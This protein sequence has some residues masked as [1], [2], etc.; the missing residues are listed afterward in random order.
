MSLGW[1]HS[2]RILWAATGSQPQLLVPSL[3]PPLGEAVPKLAGRVLETETA[4]PCK[5]N[6]PPPLQN[7]VGDCFS[8][9]EGAGVEKAISNDF[10]GMFKLEKDVVPKVCKV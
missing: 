10:A 8:G 3:F 5:A 6:P 4:F 2:Q 9:E 7:T 1:Y